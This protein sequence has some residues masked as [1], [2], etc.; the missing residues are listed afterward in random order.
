MPDNLKAGVTRADRYEPDLNPTYPSWPPT[1]ARPSSRPR[2]RK[3]RD[4]AKVENG[5]LIVERWI[6]AAAAEPHLLQPRRAQRGDRGAAR[7][8]S[9]SGRFQKLPG[10]R[11]SLFET[12]DRPALKPL[13]AQP[14]EFAEWKKARVNIDYHVEVDGHYYSVP[15]QLVDQQVELRAHG[16][17]VEILLKGR[18]VASHRRSARRGHHTT[19]PAHMPKAHQRY[20]EWTPSRILAW[21]ADDRP[22]RPAPGGVHP[23]A[24]GPIPSRASAPAWASCAWDNATGRSGW[25]P[26]APGPCGATARSATAA[27]SRSSRR[28]STGRPQ[29]TDAQ[30]TPSPSR[31][32][33][34]SAAP[35][36]TTERSARPMLTERDP[37]EAR[38]P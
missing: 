14:Y 23:G 1:T 2:V 8:S 15:Y 5:V 31:S 3:P 30:P 34:T 10:S 36:T 29:P 35:T 27:S 6:L 32:T 11:R 22:R 7:L 4:K 18:R 20:L 17:I 16:T 9:T 24:A 26:P 21:A 28:D 12:L 13:P 38:A 33:P 25:R 37:R 19:E